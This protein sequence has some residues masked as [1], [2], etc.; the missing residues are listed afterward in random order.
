MFIGRKQNGECYGAWICKQ[1]DDADHPGIEE[2]T[3]DHP[4]LLAFINRPIP[5]AKD[6]LDQIAA[7]SPARKA[8]LK[9]ELSK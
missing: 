4:E 1:P 7:L 3:D 8:L 2:V 5:L 6:I 9:A